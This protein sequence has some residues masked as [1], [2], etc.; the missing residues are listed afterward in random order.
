MDKK[1]HGEEMD[2]MP[3]PQKKEDTT[4]TEFISKNK[5]VIDKIARSNTRINKSGLTV[6]P[7]D[8]TWLD[9]TEW[10]EMYNNLKKK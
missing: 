1:Y 5:D 7:K 10:D 8:D 3:I 6:I 2:K 4:F 9:E